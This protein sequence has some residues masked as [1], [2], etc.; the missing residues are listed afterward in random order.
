RTLADG[1]AYARCYTS[2]RQRRDALASWIHFYNHHRPHTAC[3]NLPPIT[4][5]TNIPDQYN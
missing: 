5:L 1:W 4:R 2:E 3:G